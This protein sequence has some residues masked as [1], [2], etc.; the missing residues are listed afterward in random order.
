MYVSKTV[1]L[2]CAGV[3]SRL[4]L[5]VTKALL[6]LNGKTL[7]HR[8]LEML[9]QVEDV[10]IV[11]GYQ[12]E[13]VINAVL[14]LRRDV[15]FVF[16]HK[17]NYTNTATSL[18]LGAK[19]ANEWLISWDGDL[20]VHPQDFQ[21]FFAL[22]EE[23][24]AYTITDTENPIYVLPEERQDGTYIKAFSQQLCTGYEWT[25]LVQIKTIK[26]NNHYPYIYQMLEPHLPIK[27]LKIRSCE[28]DTP[29]DYEVALRWLKEIQHENTYA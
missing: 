14:P 28:I 4:G 15:T 1:V 11:V 26:I 3:G 17:F 12:A 10:R 16:N 27:G 19:A 2:N 25:G 7:I 24:L 21:S 29:H 8:Q 18:A 20:L 23:Y 13:Q 5:G 6:K 22:N 9:E